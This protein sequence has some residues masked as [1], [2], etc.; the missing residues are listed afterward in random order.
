[1]I[2]NDISKADYRSALMTMFDQID[3]RNKYRA[4]SAG[5]FVIGS[6]SKKTFKQA[7]TVNFLFNGVFAAKTTQAIALTATTHD[8]AASASSVQEAIYLITYSAADGT[9]VVTKGDTATGSGA[10]VYPEIPAA[11]VPVGAVR[12]AVAAGATSFDATSDDLDAAHL[13]CTYYDLGWLAP[14]FDAV[15]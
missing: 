6:V 7:N 13:T 10:A 4:L 3:T 15:V 5:G 1:M 8:I 2:K 14:R 9:T 11:S 12:I